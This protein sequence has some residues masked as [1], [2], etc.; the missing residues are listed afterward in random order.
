MGLADLVHRYD[1][2]DDKAQE[3]GSQFFTEPDRRILYVHDIRLDGSYHFYDISDIVQAPII[4]ADY[5]Y[6]NALLTQ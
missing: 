5:L 2:R 6:R 4:A 3:L 1:T